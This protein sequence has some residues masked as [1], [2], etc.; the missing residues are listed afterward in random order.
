M[1]KLTMRELK[2][3]KGGVGEGIEW[4]AKRFGYRTEKGRIMYRKSG[5]K[6]Q[7]GSRAH[8]G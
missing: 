2:T 8:F 4:L 3:V 1:E 7:I 6:P 5:R